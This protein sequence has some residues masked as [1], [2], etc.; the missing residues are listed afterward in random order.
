ML[1]K[2]DMELLSVIQLK[3]YAKSLDIN[4]GN[5]NKAELIKVIL[6]V[7]RK[8][9]K[10]KS[11]SL[12][13]NKNVNKTVKERNVNNNLNQKSRNIKK[14]KEI[15]KGVPPRNGNVHTVPT[16]S[17]FPNIKHILKRT[18]AQ[19]L[20]G[21][22]SPNK[23]RK[24]SKNKK[25]SIVSQIGNKGKEGTTYHVKNSKGH[26]FAMKTFRGNKSISN[27]KHEAELQK[28]AADNKLSPKVIEVDEINK[29]IIMDLCET[30][31]FDLLKKTN[32]VI[33]EYVQDE[34]VKIIKSLDKIG[35]F[36]GDPNP[37]NFMFRGDKLYIIDFGF[38]K[39]IDENLIKSYNGVKKL[40]HKF[41]ILG[42]MLKVKELFKQLNPNLQFSI[43][44]DEISP[45]EREFFN[46]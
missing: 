39:K 2:N 1:T 18:Q 20:S 36:H 35:I 17:T 37:L 27:L 7:F 25:Y 31:L 9:N 15:Y 34:I 14:K 12:V 41:M 21:E 40:N 29:Y 33:T 44:R 19:N 13:G 4:I 46:L 30:N 38:A 26:D 5:N 3:N 23:S 8:N 45:K 43:L 11:R 24:V 28:K 10:L 16:V 42:F 6:K 22:T 32:G